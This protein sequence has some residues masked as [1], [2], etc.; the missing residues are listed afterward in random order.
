MLEREA[1]VVPSRSVFTRIVPSIH[2]LVINPG[3]SLKCEKSYPFQVRWTLSVLGGG[4]SVQEYSCNM[5]CSPYNAILVVV[6]LVQPTRAAGPQAPTL[7]PPYQPLV[8]ARPSPTPP[9]A[10]AV[11]AQN[12][13]RP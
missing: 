2:V 7:T 12:G 3:A 13:P 5:G 10:G 9:T 6:L 8:P 11:R 1:C 4:W